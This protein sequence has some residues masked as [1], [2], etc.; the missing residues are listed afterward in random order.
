MMAGVP[1][2][3]QLAAVQEIGGAA[4]GFGGAAGAPSP[5]WCRLRQGGA[6]GPVRSISSDQTFPALHPPRCLL[7]QPTA[8][9]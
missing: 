8:D 6:G 1:R 2:L 4:V 3:G 5:P 9:R 7:G